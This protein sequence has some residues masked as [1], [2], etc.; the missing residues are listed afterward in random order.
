M[1]LVNRLGIKV[2]RL[3]Q[4]ALSPFVGMH[5]K[6]IPSCSQYACDCFT[7]YGFLKSFRLI[8]WR[9]L[10]CNPWSQGGHDPAVKPTSHH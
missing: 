1:R 8:V 3:Y 10:R 2:V 4:I 7:S 9:I 6:F 5:C